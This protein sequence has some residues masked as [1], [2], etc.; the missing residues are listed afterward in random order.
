MELKKGLA[1]FSA[2]TVATS[3]FAI[4]IK[5]PLIKTLYEK[6]ILTE[7]E[8]LKL[9]KRASTKI[10][11]KDKKIK[12]GGVGYIGYTYIDRKNGTDSGDFEIRRGYFITKFYLNDKDYVRFTLDVTKHH[13]NDNANN[14]QEIDIKLKH[15]YLYEDISNY[16]PYTGFEFGLVHTPWLDYE[17]HSGWWYRSISKT[18]Y[19]SANGAHLL[20]SAD[21]GV[22]FKT[23]TK[24][25]S[26]EYGI[27]NGE[28]YDHIG[29]SDKGNNGNKP[30]FEGRITFSPFGT[31][32]KHVNPLK[33][34]YLDI[35][36]HGVDSIDHRGAD[37]DL[38]IYQLHAVY[39][40]PLF[41]VAGQY[42]K[43][44]WIDN[45]EQ[46]GYGYSFNFEV[47]PLLE[48]RISFFGRYDNWNSDNNQF[49]RKQ[50]I[51]GVAWYM[52]KY[53]KW[54][55]NAINTDYDKNNTRD[56]NRYMLTAD[57]EF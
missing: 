51:Y 48:H 37:K 52:N 11:S 8:A 7:E 3:S 17:E 19:E 27:F 16:V 43:S 18:F 44:S 1:I 21:L 29:Q 42:I 4:D 20:P 56:E 36:L 24:F 47:R 6:G 26:A 2:L 10:E 25:F 30:S 50:Y 53:I 22:D 23:K 14:G 12:I 32:N 45:S 33:D 5:N 39:N 38:T 31:G 57:L 35:S 46:D 9:D 54:I 40:Q 41:L 13:H 15:F 34:E 49:D 28:G 55:V